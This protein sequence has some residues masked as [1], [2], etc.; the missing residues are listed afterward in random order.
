MNLPKF[1]QGRYSF[2]FLRDPVERVLSFYYYCQSRHP[3]VFKIN[4]LAHENELEQFIELAFKDDLIHSRIVN[5]QAWQMAYGYK[6]NIRVRRDV[7]DDELLELS[8]NHLDPFSYVAFTETFEEDSRLILSHL[9]LPKYD[10][11]ARSNVNTKRPG[12]KDISPTAL[13][14]IRECTRVDQKLY[15]E[16]LS[17]RKI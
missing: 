6:Q 16:A 10:V 8:I 7:S 9:G 13:E 5:N 14:L 15:T 11:K 2:V 1:L 17:R 4:R 12:C 3:D